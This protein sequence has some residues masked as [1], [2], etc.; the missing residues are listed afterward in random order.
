[1]TTTAISQVG[2]YP[3]LIIGSIILILILKFILIKFFA[4]EEPK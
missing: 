4:G 2:I 1:M 3:F